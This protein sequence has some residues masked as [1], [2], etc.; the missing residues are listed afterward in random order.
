M[1]KRSTKTVG[2]MLP[3]MAAIAGWLILARPWETLTERA[4]RVCSECG[5]S[6]TEIAWLIGVMHEHPKTREELRGDFRVFFDDPDDLAWCEPCA[7]A[8][9][10]AAGLPRGALTLSG[11]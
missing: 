9:L 7:E 6:T 5:L 4:Y 8:V 3:I 10:D 2:A 11:T 1:T